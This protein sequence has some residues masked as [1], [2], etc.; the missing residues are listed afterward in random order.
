[1]KINVYNFKMCKELR[2]CYRISKI[3]FDFAIIFN[4]PFILKYKVIYA[5]RVENKKRATV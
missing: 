1:M 4:D 2:A 5:S 3:L